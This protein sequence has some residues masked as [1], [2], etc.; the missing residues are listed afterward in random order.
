[1]RP[2]FTIH[3]GE[4]LTASEIEKRFPDLRVWIPSKDTG[5]DLLVTDDRQNK[6]ASL[7]VKFS[8]DYLGT[9]NQAAAPSE[10]ASSGWWT[11]H[12]HKIATSAADFWVLI[13]YQFQKRN[14]DFI[15]ISPL[16]LLARYDELERKDDIIQSYFCVTRAGRCWEIRRLGENGEKEMDKIRSGEDSTKARDFSA[17]LNA[18][19]F[20]G[21]KQSS[22]A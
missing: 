8:K 20:R 11:F 21:R 14:F 9:A 19:P 3:A 7:Q 13:L 12:R 17:Y 1:M 6:V 15:V 10:I 5:I 18:W 2:I 22:A 16:D 4:Y